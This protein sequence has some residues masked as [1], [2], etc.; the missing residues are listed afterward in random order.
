MSSSTFAPRRASR[1]GGR[2]ILVRHGESEGNRARTFTRHSEVPITERGRDQARAAAE[3]IARRFAPTRVVSSPFARARQTAELLA[4]PFGL[5]LELEPAFR[6]QS[7]GVFAGQ[8][9]ASLARDAVGDEQPRWTWRPEGGESLSDVYARVVPAFERVAAECRGRETMIVS[10]GGVM[11]ALC[12]YLTGSW[13]G[14]TVAPNAGVLLVTYS[15][16][17]FS[18]PESLPDD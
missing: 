9:Y 5:P 3:R 10:H 17:R 2:L 4:A 18:R 13:E 6:E 8:P 16:G 14:L 15:A 11:L 7:F 1:K 12:A